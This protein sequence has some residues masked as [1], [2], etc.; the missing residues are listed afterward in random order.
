MFGM[1]EALHDDLPARDMLRVRDAERP[2][3]RASDA[4]R[5]QVAAT[6]GGA[7]AAVRP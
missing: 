1:S 6:L 7:L 5:D 2:D 3:L 4:D